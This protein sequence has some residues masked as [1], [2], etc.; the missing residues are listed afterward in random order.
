MVSDLKRKVWDSK[1]ELTQSG[2]SEK[3]F[4]D[5]AMA[6]LR[7]GLKGKLTRAMGRVV[8]AADRNEAVQRSCD[9]NPALRRTQRKVSVP[10]SRKQGR[11]WCMMRLGSGRELEGHC[12]PGTGSLIHLFTP[13]SNLMSAYVMSTDNKKDRVIFETF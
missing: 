12:K 2:R 10:E 7:A 4:L 11:S 8:R 1:V 5:G 6:K 13:A 9:R 3:V